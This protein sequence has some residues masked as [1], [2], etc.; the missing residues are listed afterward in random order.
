M[1]EDC[2]ANVAFTTNNYDSPDFAWSLLAPYP[3]F[4]R[5]REALI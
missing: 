1:Y 3:E 4:T 5:C 2:D